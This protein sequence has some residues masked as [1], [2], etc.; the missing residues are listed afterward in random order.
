L[1]PEFNGTQPVQTYIG[2][3]PGAGVRRQR[4]TVRYRLAIPLA[5]ARFGSAPSRPGCGWGPGGSREDR[6]PAG[7]PPPGASRRCA[8]GLPRLAADARDLVLSRTT[9]RA[10]LSPAGSGNTRAV[11][12][13][14]A[15]RTRGS[16]KADPPVPRRSPRQP[17]R[18]GRSARQRHQTATTVIPVTPPSDATG[19]GVLVGAAEDAREAGGGLVLRAP[20]RAMRRTA[21]DGRDA[22]SASMTRARESPRRAWPD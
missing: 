20:S 21:A 7:V 12:P 9:G 6:V 13:G 18:C 3:V 19:T 14:H 15:R 4:G 16:R 11:L 22:A 10:Y 5:A 17:R 2:R 8:G 1:K